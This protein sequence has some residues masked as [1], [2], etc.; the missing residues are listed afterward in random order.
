[1]L[2]N[3]ATSHSAEELLKP[4]LDATLSLAANNLE[5]TE[6]G[7][8][9]LQPLYVLFYGQDSSTPLQPGL[10]DLPSPNAIFIPPANSGI[11]S[12]LADTAAANAETVFWKVVEVLKEVKRQRRT[13]AEGEE[14][15]DDELVIENFWPP[16]SDIS[17]VEQD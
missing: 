5:T 17:V 1:M 8:S 15:K 10:Q 14:T 12:E 4:Y 13:A 16:I 2:L 7:S 11:I 3:E 9:P 6:S